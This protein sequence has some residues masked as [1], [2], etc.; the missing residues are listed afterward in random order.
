MLSSE[1]FDGDE[2]IV[3]QGAEADG[4]YFLFE[5]ECKAFICGE[6][7]EV[8]VKHYTR[9]GEY[10]GEI[11]LIT[12]EPRRATVRACDD[13]CVVLK[14]KKEDVDLSVGCIRE[15]LLADI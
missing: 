3:Q 13:G 8:E 7:G 12:N 10:F 4:V 14:L 5:G 15:R 1:L 9:P 11:A 6:Q 2:E